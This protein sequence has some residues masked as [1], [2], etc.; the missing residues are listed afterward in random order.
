MNSLDAEL[1]GKI[2]ILSP[3]VYKGNENERKFKCLG[4]FGCSPHT[5]GTAV[6]GRLLHAGVEF[7]AEGYEIE[8]FADDEGWKEVSN[9]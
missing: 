7:R 3:K 1:E 4:G 2:V 5:R 6:F 9:E 8:K